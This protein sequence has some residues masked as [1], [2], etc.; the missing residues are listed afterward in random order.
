MLLTELPPV[1]VRKKDSDLLAPIVTFPKLNVVELIVKVPLL[2]PDP[3]NVAVIGVSAAIPLLYAILIVCS[4]VT[5]AT[6]G[7]YVTVIVQVPP[8]ETLPQVVV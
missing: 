1:F 8:A 6:N 5:P 4:G 3:L 2:T 7:L